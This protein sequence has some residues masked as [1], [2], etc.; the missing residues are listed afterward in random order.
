M[1]LTTMLMIARKEQD[2]PTSRNTRVQ[3][4]LEAWMLYHQD[5]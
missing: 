5:H 4:L 1:E 2:E 3:S